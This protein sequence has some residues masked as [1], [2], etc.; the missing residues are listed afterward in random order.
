LHEDIRFKYKDVHVS[1]INSHRKKLET[2]S[3][4]SSR[5]LDEKTHQWLIGSHV[6]SSKVLS[7]L[8]SQSYKPDLAFTWN[9]ITSEITNPNISLLNHNQRST[10]FAQK[11]LFTPILQ[12]HDKPPSH[13]WPFYLLPVHHTLPL[14]FYPLF[15]LASMTH[16]FNYI[17]AKA[18]NSLAQL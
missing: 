12:S 10:Q 14:P 15:R 8:F 7:L 18:L 1:N 5:Q 11:I 13:C 6:F 9:C 4:S 17:H 2:I 3:I 16:H